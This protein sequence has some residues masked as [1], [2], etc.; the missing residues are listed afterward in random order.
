MA[1]MEEINAIMEAHPDLKELME[2]SPEAFRLTYNAFLEEK[3]QKKEIEVMEDE[4]KYVMEQ[5][6]SIAENNEKQKEEHRAKLTELQESISDKDKEID[7]L[8]I[9]HKEH[10]DDHM[11]LMEQVKLDQEE[12]QGKVREFKAASEDERAA[13]F[14]ALYD[15]L[16]EIDC[17]WTFLKDGELESVLKK[18]GDKK[19]DED[20]RAESK[21]D[22][23]KAAREEG[24]EKNETNAEKEGNDDGAQSTQLPTE[25]NSVVEAGAGDENMDG[26]AESNEDAVPA[27][28]ASSVS[29]YPTNQVIVTGKAASLHGGSIQLSHGSLPAFAP[30]AVPL[31]PTVAPQN[32]LKLTPTSLRTQIPIP[33]LICKPLIAPMSFGRPDLRRSTVGGHSAAAPA[34]APAVPLS[35]SSATVL[36]PVPAAEPDAKE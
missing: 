13:K 19:E 35:V 14:H 27:A 15:K 8:K 32:L 28:R 7:R 10:I 36:A 24:N 29:R 3:K 4:V 30:R 23:E 25:D 18:K 22:K 16:G 34:T 2:L 1:T 6:D 17:N 31:R 26:N 33:K 21:A 12:T 9:Q 20:K 5:I 11:K